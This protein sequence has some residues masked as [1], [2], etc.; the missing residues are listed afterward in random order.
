MAGE[1]GNSRKMLLILI[2]Q[3][4]V[5][6][7]ALGAIFAFTLSATEGSTAKSGSKPYQG[8]A[9]H[10]VTV[11]KLPKDFMKDFDLSDIRLPYDLSLIHI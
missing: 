9:H 10:E 3:L 7:L 11:P 8:N 1:Q 4:L 2:I 6:F 5:I